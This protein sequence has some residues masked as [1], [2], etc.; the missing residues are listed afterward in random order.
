MRHD[1]LNALKTRQTGKIHMADG[2]QSA[3]QTFKWDDPFDLNG[4]LTEDERAKVGAW[5]AALH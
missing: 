5:I 1:P 2:A 3:V 4:R